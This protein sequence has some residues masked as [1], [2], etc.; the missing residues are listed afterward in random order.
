MTSSS[1]NPN[2]LFSRY[3]NQPLIY[4]EQL[5]INQLML[6]ITSLTESMAG[7]FYC[8]ASYANS[9][10][11]EE[12]VRIETYTA[13]TWKDAPLIQT[14]VVGDDYV[15]RCIVTANPPPTVGKFL[16]L[17]NAEK[18]W[19]FCRRLDSQWGTNQVFRPLHHQARW[20]ANQRRSGV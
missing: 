17:K 15:V 5:N 14:P 9:E 2:T 6:V 1:L 4:T 11:L 3:G 16:N 12:K 13:I 8:Q 19:K 18:S 20:V 10:L 7:N